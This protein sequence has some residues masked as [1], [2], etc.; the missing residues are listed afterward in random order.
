MPYGVAADHYLLEA[1]REL[2]LE[3]AFI[4]DFQYTKSKILR[5]KSMLDDLT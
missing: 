1:E 3:K 5:L 2:Q 4:E